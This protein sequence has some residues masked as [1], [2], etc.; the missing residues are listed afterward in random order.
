MSEIADE[1]RHRTLRY[2][3]RI[4]RLCR[5]L[6][7]TWVDREV[8]KQL[9]LAGMAVT[10]KYWSSSGGRSDKEFLDGLKDAIQGTDDSVLWL[11]VIVQSSIWDDL[12]VKSVL[13]EGKEIRAILS[14]SHKTARENRRRR[15]QTETP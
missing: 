14:A 8:G 1:L 3:L 11:T 4:I 7:E 9:L 2:T 5:K 6:P 15:K 10:R 12:E 13:G